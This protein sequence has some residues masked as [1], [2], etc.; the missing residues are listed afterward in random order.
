MTIL[1]K[2][3]LFMFFVLIMTTISLAVDNW[4]TKGLLIKIQSKELT[5]RSL[6]GTPCNFLKEK[7][8]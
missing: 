2:L 3:T 5:C 6:C 4:K 1:G 8:K 7:T